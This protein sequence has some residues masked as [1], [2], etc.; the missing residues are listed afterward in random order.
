VPRFLSG[1]RPDER[2]RW[3]D[4]NL[5]LDDSISEVI[6]NGAD[7]GLGKA[8]DKPAR[9][10]RPGV[11]CSTGESGFSISAAEIAGI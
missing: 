5:I 7:R 11:I 4:A 1:I 10:P 2:R 3:R 9:E 8:A 6:V